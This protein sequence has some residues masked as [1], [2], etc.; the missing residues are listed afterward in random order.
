MRGRKKVGRREWRERGEQREVAGSDDRERGEHE[1][2][3]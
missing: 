1:D 2:T 3:I